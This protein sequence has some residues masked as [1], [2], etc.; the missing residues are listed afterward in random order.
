MSMSPSAAAIDL[1]ESF[2]IDTPYNPRPTWPGGAS[3]VTIGVG[4]DCGYQSAAQIKADWGDL[5]PAGVV[6]RLQ[7]Y[8]GR[9]GMQAQRLAQVAQDIMVPRAAAD[10]VFRAR[11]IPRYADL[12]ARTFRCDGLSPDSFGALVSLVFNRG[13]GMSDPPSPPAPWQSRREMRQIRDALLAGRPDQVPALIRVMKRLWVGKGLDGLIRRREAEAC[14]F[15][16]G[17]GLGAGN[18]PPPHEITADDLMAAELLTL[19]GT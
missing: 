9:A 3:G 15:E 2:E 13:A 7:S 6:T 11:D 8:A 1:I 12:T 16:R 5:L 10:T 18:A 14:L 17:L 19:K 4:Y